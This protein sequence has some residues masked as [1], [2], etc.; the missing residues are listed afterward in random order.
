MNKLWCDANEEAPQGWIWVKTYIDALRE[1]RAENIKVVSIAYDLGRP[2]CD[3]KTPCQVDGEWV[4]QFGKC[5]CECHNN[6]TGADLM[7]WM[8][9]RMTELPE[10]IYVRPVGPLQE[11]LM[12]RL[13]STMMR[14][15]TMVTGI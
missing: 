11:R 7:H 10:F 4:C 8:E 2:L 3:T 13:L 6:R 1:L 9:A 12:S 5:K 14:S 15:R